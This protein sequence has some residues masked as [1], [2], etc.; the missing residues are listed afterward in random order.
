MSGIDIGIIIIYFAVIIAIGFYVAKKYVKTG[1]DASVA[2]RKLGIF[3]GGIGKAAN[4]AG[5]SSS[6]GGTSWGYQLGIG[7]MW[8]AVSEGFT[9]IV[10]L[11]IIKR[12][13]TVLYRTRTSSVGQFFGYRWGG[14][15]RLFAGLINAVCY[16]AFVGAQIIA[17]ATV[18]RL[19]LGWDYVAALLVST[20]II[21]IYCTAG[22]LRA[23]VITDVIQMALIIAGMLIIMPPIV[24]GAAG[25]ALGGGGIAAVWEALKSNELTASMTNFGAPAVFGWPYI[26]GAI[27]LPTI[28]IG[29][30][31]QASYQYQS[32]I[33][34]AD[35]A[36][37][38]FI[39]VPFLYIPVSI[40]VVLM[41]MCAMILYGAEYLPVEY[42]GGGS[43]PNMILS[44][45]IEQFL[46]SGLTGLLLAAILSA[47]MS[48]S[49]TC[50]IC[51]VTCLTEDVIKP[52]LRKKP[53]NKE[54]LKL[55]R[56]CMVLI[57]LGTIGITLWVT[58]IIQLLT[59]GYSAAIAGLWVPIMATI[60]YK[61]ATK[62][63]TYIT[64]L[65]GLALYG[66]MSFV[67]AAFSFLPAAIVS[68][69]LYL[70]LPLSIVLI[71]AISAGTQKSDHGRIDAYFE[72]EWEKSPGN[73]EKHPEI[74]EDSGAA[75]AEA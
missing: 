27:I 8:Y 23:I 13:W 50:L 14:G 37:K 4:S 40:M 19:M 38:S 71:F 43:D 68:A 56:I 9:Y 12:M 48:T 64:M 45:L 1:D 73:W 29:G 6:V 59:T 41:G 58:D 32:A 39:M 44:T 21:I 53:S 28:L 11:P 74:L 54:A 7:G 47:T 46:P 18:I 75:P 65:V 66:A 26:I 72:D 52:Y 60:F 49:S 20:A 25:D 5:G 69:P 17:T 31:A 34:T 16:M 70:T 2:G 63:A 10:Y 36:F 57:G 67:P 15:A 22:G 55:F 42:G 62:P 3:L 35:K 51:S 61:K 33:Q 24:F 30:V